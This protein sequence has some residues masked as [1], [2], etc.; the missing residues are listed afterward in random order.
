MIALVRMGRRWWL[1][2]R[3][4]GWVPAAT[5]PEAFAIA[6]GIRVAAEGWR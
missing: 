1:P 4:G 3:T 2:L 6:H 5:I